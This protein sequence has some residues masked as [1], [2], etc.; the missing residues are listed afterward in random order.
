M[1]LATHNNNGPL[2]LVAIALGLPGAVLLRLTMTRWGQTHPKQATGAKVLGALLLFASGLFAAL[3][4]FA[5]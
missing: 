2:W 5:E 1:T 4:A 3:A